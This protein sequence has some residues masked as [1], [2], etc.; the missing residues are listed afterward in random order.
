MNQSKSVPM[1]M[2][3]R[4]EK[5]PAMVY[6]PTN[7]GEHKIVF[8]RDE[9]PEGWVEHPSDVGADNG[10]EQRQ[11]SKANN[12]AQEN[13]D[14]GEHDQ[15]KDQGGSVKPSK[16]AVNNAKPDVKTRATRPTL[17]SL[18]MTA[19]E[20]MDFLDDKGVAFSD[21]ASDQE[22]ATLVAKAKNG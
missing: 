16:R 14:D 11:A 5:Y 9:I 18:K 15:H 20:A 22:L 7:V 8:T 1:Y 2:A 6:H 13:D 10:N 21:T 12:R 4:G 17:K 19:D 3:N